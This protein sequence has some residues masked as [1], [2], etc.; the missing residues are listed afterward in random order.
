MDASGGG[1]ECKRWYVSASVPDPSPPGIKVY[2]L[3][4][5]SSPGVRSQ[6]A[7]RERLGHRTHSYGLHHASRQGGNLV[8]RACHILFYKMYDILY[9]VSGNT[10]LR[11]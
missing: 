1:G 2:P 5:F 7:Q 9:D 4:P 8:V 11:T 10:E 6:P 3:L